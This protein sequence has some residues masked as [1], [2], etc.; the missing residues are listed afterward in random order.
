MSLERMPGVVVGL[1]TRNDDPEGLGRVKLSYPMLEPGNESGW[2]RLLAPYA[3]EERGV[4]FVPEVGDEVMVAFE[5]GDPNFP[6]VV[7]SVWSL[8]AKPPND[9]PDPDNNIK[10]IRTRS[11][12]QITFDDTDG[13]EL[14]E[15]LDSSGNN[16][17]R[18]D[19]SGD[20]IEIEAKTGSVLVS[21]PKGAIQL[22]AKTIEVKSSEN[23]VVSAG[24]ELSVSAGTD[25]AFEAK[26]GLSVSA[27]G[28]TIK[29]SQS[30]GVDGGG[31]LT[32]KAGLIDIN[33]PA[34][35]TQVQSLQKMATTAASGG[36]LQAMAGGL[37]DL[38][39]FLPEVTGGDILGMIGFDGLKMPDWLKG[40]LRNAL[41]TTLNG[42]IEAIKTGD[43]SAFTDGLKS[44]GGGLVTDFGSQISQKAGDFLRD[45]ISGAGGQ[46]LGDLL[47]QN[48]DNAWSQTSQLIQ[49]GDVDAFLSGLRDGAIQTTTDILYSGAVDAIEGLWVPDEGDALGGGPMTGED[50][51]KKAGGLWHDVA[52]GDTLQRIAQ[53]RYGDASL[54]Q[55]IA[56]A[57]PGRVGKTATDL[58]LVGT[59]LKIPLLGGG[60]D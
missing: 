51:A 57:N 16:V 60:D 4:Y 48:L 56:D 7:G 55:Q 17:I 43:F 23:T 52:I 10:R 44:A 13:K 6:Y 46:L 12:H 9:G 27:K 49:D 36:G 19:V 5:H 18:M 29:T 26:K 50:P 45:N 8:P 28:G 3:G 53:L 32:L 31:Q 34:G 2:A 22:D 1:V 54:W 15:I 37:G 21:A 24:K 39:G 40:P 20:T 30:L 58:I 25:A 14:I 47:Q 59:S 35:G 38:A 41:E 42:A 11:G 33:P